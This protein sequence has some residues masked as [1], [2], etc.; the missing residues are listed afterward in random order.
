MATSDKHPPEHV[1]KKNFHLT[2]C[3]FAESLKSQAAK[4]ELSGFGKEANALRAWAV[5]LR[6]RSSHLPILEKERE[7]VSII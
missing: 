6:L 1:C 7:N 4:M 5:E 2:A 3:E